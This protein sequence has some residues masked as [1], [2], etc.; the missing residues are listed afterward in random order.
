MKP[1]NNANNQQLNWFWNLTTRWWF[2]IVFYI[3]ASFVLEI[4]NLSTGVF[5]RSEF[6]GFFA[7][8]LIFLMPSGIISLLDIAFPVGIGIGVLLIFAYHALL[9]SSMI[10]IPYFKCKKGKTLKWLIV[11]SIFIIVISLF[12]YIF[13]QLTN[14]MYTHQT[15]FV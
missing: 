15:G 10:A 8:N 4:F 3:L 2:F 6:L 14:Y 12:G 1:D 7:A 13:S 9:L 5:D 11:I